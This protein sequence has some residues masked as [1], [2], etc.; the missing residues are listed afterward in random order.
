MFQAIQKLRRYRRTQAFL[1]S[2]GWYYSHSAQLKGM[3]SLRDGEKLGFSD[4]GLLVDFSRV[5]N[6]KRVDVCLSE[7]RVFRRQL[8]DS[9][10][11]FSEVASLASSSLQ[12]ERTCGEIAQLGIPSQGYF[13]KINYAFGCSPRFRQRTT[14]CR[15]R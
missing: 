7:G 2:G 14:S 15:R 8:R 10:T 1:A 6:A 9:Y 4:C 12:V 13:P 3:S 11:G 5:H